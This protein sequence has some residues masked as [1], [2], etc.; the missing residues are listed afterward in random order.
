MKVKVVPSDPS[1]DIFISDGSRS[2]SENGITF[3][4]G[5]PF[6]IVLN[7]NVTGNSFSSTVAKNASQLVKKTPVGSSTKNDCDK[8]SLCAITVLLVWVV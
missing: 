3:V 8:G 2:I 1:L 4:V 7:W 5:N 6:C